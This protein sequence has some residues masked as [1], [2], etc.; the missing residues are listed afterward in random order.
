MTIIVVDPSDVA[1]VTL[2][3][4]N[5]GTTT[6]SSVSY[7]TPQQ[8]VTVTA[9]SNTTTTTTFRVSTM[10]H[11]RTYQILASAT[12]STGEVLNRHVVLRCF[13]G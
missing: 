7:T 5:L 13:H 10:L 12:L 11:G 3:W 6:I 2:T 8:G 1:N 4:D 9:V